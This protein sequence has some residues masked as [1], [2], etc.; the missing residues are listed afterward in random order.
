MTKELEKLVN[1]QCEG[2][3]DFDKLSKRHKRE[4]RRKLLRR[5]YKGQKIKHSG[6]FSPI[7]PWKY[8]GSE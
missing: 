8:K 4:L 2:I 5:I 1:K 7:K 3:K 6:N